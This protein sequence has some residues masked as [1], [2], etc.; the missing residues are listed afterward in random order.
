M[1]YTTKVKVATVNFCLFSAT[2]LPFGVTLGQAG[3]PSVGLLQQTYYKSD[4]L[5]V[6]QTTV[7]I[8]LWEHE[9]IHFFTCEG[10]KHLGGHG[11]KEK[12]WDLVILMLC[13]QKCITVTSLV[14]HV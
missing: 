1:F 5:P 7:S 2:G 11:N 4:A 12:Q 9:F 8:A 3:S 13:C 10:H 6:T 14:V